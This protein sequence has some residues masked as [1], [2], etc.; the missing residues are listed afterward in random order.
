VSP[1]GEGEFDFSHLAQ[2]SG[3]FGVFAVKAEVC[4]ERVRCHESA[5]RNYKVATLDHYTGPSHELDQK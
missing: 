3:K 2:A 1:Q 5:P 4:V